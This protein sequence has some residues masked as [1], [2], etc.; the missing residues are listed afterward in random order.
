MSQSSVTEAL[1]QKPVSPE[2]TQGVKT[3]DLVQI[4]KVHIK[5]MISV[6]PDSYFFPYIGKC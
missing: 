3:Q 4:T 5:G 6:S 2:E 1:Q